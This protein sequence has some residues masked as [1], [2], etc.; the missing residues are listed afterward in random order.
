MAIPVIEQ[1]SLGEDFVGA[2]HGSEVSFFLERIE[3]EGAGPRLHRH[4][5]SETFVIRSG[6]ARFTVS[7][8]QIV[9]CGGQI[10]VVPALVAHRF[11]VVGSET[12][13][14]IH[15]H[16]SDRFITEWLE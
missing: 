15:I 10:L 8:E 6:A 12:Y 7:D 3:R 13:E 2:A 14:A 4:P 11:A 9:A 16:A 5:Y 1:S